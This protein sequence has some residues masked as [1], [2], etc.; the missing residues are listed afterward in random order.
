MK[1]KAAAMKRA[2][3]A[4]EEDE[5]HKRL[6]VEKPSKKDKKAKKQKKEKKEKKAKK[7]KKETSK[8]EQKEE[9]PDPNAF[10]GVDTDS[11]DDEAPVII[12][13]EEANLAAK[14][15][16]AALYEALEAAKTLVSG[17]EDDD[18]EEEDE[19]EAGVPATNE[20][21]AVPE[22]DRTVYVEG[23][24]YEASEASIR[25]FFSSAGKIQ[26]L[27]LPRYVP[28]SDCVGFSD[29]VD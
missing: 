1:T 21:S 10:L 11:D 27:R 18:E 25:E 9:V 20:P 12:E 3:E 13:S 17:D 29:S 6:K 2:G 4:V 19:E 24:P 8:A 15:K 5:I 23:I 28:R 26:E 14:Q 16:N 7:A 22:V